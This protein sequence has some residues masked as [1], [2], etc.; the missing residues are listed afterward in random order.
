MIEQLEK[1]LNN[2]P[3]KEFDG[4]IADEKVIMIKEAVSKHI[5]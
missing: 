1:Y 5:N 2:D 4:S 3:V